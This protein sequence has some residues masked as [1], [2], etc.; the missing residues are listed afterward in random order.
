MT[1]KIAYIEGDKN[2]E[3]L[4]KRFKRDKYTYKRFPIKN[5]KTGLDN[6]EK[7]EPEIII[8]NA[9]VPEI[10]ESPIIHSP[11]QTSTLRT[12]I[13]Q[14]I[15][16]YMSHHNTKIYVVTNDRFVEACKK[17][18]IANYLAN[19]VFNIREQTLDYMVSHMYR[20]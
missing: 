14:L 6:I 17:D 7:Y 12:E 19:E 16:T 2:L 11:H 20:K 5:I 8:I 13:H 3:S 1:Q 4:T 9:T 15:E 10:F 18:T